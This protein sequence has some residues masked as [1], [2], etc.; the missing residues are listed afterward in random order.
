MTQ[1]FVKTREFHSFQSMKN[2]LNHY[3][4]NEMDKIMY[5]QIYL[6]LDNIFK[7][8]RHQRVIKKVGFKLL[9][10]R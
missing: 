10:L 3:L 7:R 1:T 8:N 6:S 2:V 4:Y 5:D 9:L